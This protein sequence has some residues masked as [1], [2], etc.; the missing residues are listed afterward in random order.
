MSGVGAVESV[1]EYLREVESNN[2]NIY[3]TYNELIKMLK[4]SIFIKNNYT[5]SFNTTYE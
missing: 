3:N 1:W 2:G 5:N 4:F